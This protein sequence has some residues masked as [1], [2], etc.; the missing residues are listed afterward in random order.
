MLNLNSFAPL[1]QLL[2]NVSGEAYVYHRY[3]G[4]L[5]LATSA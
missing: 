2:R 3:M 4:C 1:L 5:Y